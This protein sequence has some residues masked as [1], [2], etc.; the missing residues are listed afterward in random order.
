MHP[1]ESEWW[2]RF[3]ERRRQEAEGWCVCTGLAIGE[4]E[5]LL[6]WLEVSGIDQREVTF[7]EDGVTVRWR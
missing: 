7:A 5:Q 3:G 4:A 6:D 1:G 2:K